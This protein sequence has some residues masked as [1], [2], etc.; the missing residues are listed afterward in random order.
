M[1][2]QRVGSVEVD[3]LHTGTAESAPSSPPSHEV[4]YI[5]KAGTVTLKHDGGGTSLIELHMVAVSS[6]ESEGSVGQVR[7]RE[8][9]VL[10][11]EGAT[12]LVHGDENPLPKCRVKEPRIRCRIESTC[13]FVGRLA[14]DY[15][16]LGKAVHGHEGRR[17]RII[18]IDVEGISCRINDL[19]Q[20]GA[21]CGLRD[22]TGRGNELGRR[23]S[24]ES[25]GENEEAEEVVWFARTCAFKYLRRKRLG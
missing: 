6:R 5:H 11:Q 25:R 4:I 14:R 24:D 15:R 19:H 1:R 20:T 12:I 17:T 7:G 3:E 8:Q 22:V 18:T 13:V 10:K 2:G 23:S 9:G 21:C 16:G